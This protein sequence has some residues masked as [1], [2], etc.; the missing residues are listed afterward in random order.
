MGLAATPGAAGGEVAAMIGVSILEKRYPS[1]GK[2]PPHLALSGISFRLAWGEFVAV[3]GPSGCGKTTL[4]HILAG[5]DRDFA[6]KVEIT[7]HADGSPPRIG[8]VFQ[9]PRLL[10]WRTVHENVS[11]VLR[12]DQ[13]PEIADRLIEAVGL[14]AARD[15]YPSRLSG[16][17]ARR[18]ALA[19]AFAVE[20]DLLL[21]DE[22]FVSLDPDSADNLR[23][24]LLKLWEERWGERRAT[25]LFVTHDLREALFLADR[26]LLLSAAPARLL[27][28]LP[29]EL[30]RDRRGDGAEIERLRSEVAHHHRSLM[31]K[32]SP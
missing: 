26:L 5:L 28:A 21:M 30:P 8:Y 23:A 15:A 7:P 11:L 6:G 19:R 4:L 9:N 20:P 3:S 32:A 18:A 10:P 24:L 17:M 16:G 12:P 22:P 25:I 2:A 31:S 1:V 14:G 13:N 29:L 27:A